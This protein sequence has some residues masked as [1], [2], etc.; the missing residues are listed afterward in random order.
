VHG[1]TTVLVAL[2]QPRHAASAAADVLASYTALDGAVLPIE[3]ARTHAHT[4]SMGALVVFVRFGTPSP[5]A[6]CPG[7]VAASG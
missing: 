4:I 2:P 6:G 7:V 5:P 3:G 1:R